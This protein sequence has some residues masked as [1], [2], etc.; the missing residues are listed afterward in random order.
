MCLL[1]LV[2]IGRLEEHYQNTNAPL[3]EVQFRIYMRSKEVSKSDGGA[4][5]F[6]KRQ[7]RIGLTLDSK[8]ASKLHTPI[9]QV[10]LYPLGRP[11]HVTL[12]QTLICTQLC[13]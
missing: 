4:T 7:C 2:Y 1:E 5:E 3:R 8:V 13:F 9:G 12:E 11:L 10:R 6:D